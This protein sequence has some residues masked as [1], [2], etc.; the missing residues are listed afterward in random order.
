MEHGTWFR[1]FGL[2]VCDNGFTRDRRQG[3]FFVKLLK[4][5]D[6]NQKRI[7]TP[8]NA[9][10]VLTT[11]VSLVHHSSHKTD[12]SAGRAIRRSMSSFPSTC[13]IPRYPRFRNHVF[14]PRRFRRS[15]HRSNSTRTGWYHRDLVRFTTPLDN[16]VDCTAC[17]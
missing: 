17:A 13:T 6:T 3:M 5:H 4:S 15:C 1:C 10:I 7:G 8:L 9:T 11:T 12:N 2:V 14:V 16:V